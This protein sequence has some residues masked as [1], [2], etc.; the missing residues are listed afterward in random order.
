MLEQ[1]KKLISTGENQKIEF[2]KARAD[3]PKDAF[4]TICAFLNAEG[5]TILLGVEDDGTI[6]GIKKEALNDI[7]E[8]FITS[9]NNPQIINPTLYLNIHEIEIEGKIIAYIQVPN[10]SSVYRYKSRIYLRNE[11]SDMDITDIQEEVTRLYLRTDNTYSENQL[12]PHFPINELREDIIAK[13]KKL[14]KINNAQ[15]DWNELDT[16]DFLY[17]NKLYR[18]N[19]TTGQEGITLAGILLFGTD[20]QIA[21]VAPSF[22]FELVKRVND[23]DRYD[24]RITLSTNLLDCYEIAT[25]FI[26]N[27][28]PSPFYLEGTQRISLRNLIF[29]EIIS[30]MLVHKEYMGA[31]PTKLIISKNEITAQNSNK[32][33]IRGIITPQN[34]TNFSKNPN[35]IRIFRGIGYVEDFGT[36]IPKLF[37]YCKEYTGNI[38]IIEDNNIFKITLKHN[39]FTNT[40]NIINQKV[41]QSSDTVNQKVIQSSDTVNP[42]VIQSSDT[43]KQLQTQS[44]LQKVL[45]FCESEKSTREILK[46]LGLKSKTNF[47]KRTLNPLI[48]KGLLVRT[49]PDKPNSSNQ[50]YK[51]VKTD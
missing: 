39:F 47:I 7:K 31:E 12:F 20:E 44:H 35:I 22:K 37:K 25:K 16:K 21:S 26:E 6:K 42:K 14:A 2:K 41:I 10:A 27:N 3:F 23:T 24:D 1:I 11:K 46:Y 33:H 15:S 38:P 17:R 18:R 19:Y 13:V 51:T 29:R 8:K 43:V 36:G 28:L 45:L 34:T 9:M 48:E 5:G 32:P 49:V 40:I 50:K 30:N 4:E